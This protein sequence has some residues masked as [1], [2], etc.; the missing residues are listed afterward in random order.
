[1]SKKTA[2]RRLFKWLPMSVEK[3]EIRKAIELEE[4]EEQSIDMTDSIDVLLEAKIINE[5]PPSHEEITDPKIF[6][7]RNK[8]EKHLVEAMALG[9]DPMEFFSQEKD[10]LLNSI[11]T[12]EQCMS[13]VKTITEWKSKNKEKEKK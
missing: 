12:Q 6:E 1:M 13:V 3:S 9:F 2:V 11:K 5:L 10:D 7:L 8:L 4:R